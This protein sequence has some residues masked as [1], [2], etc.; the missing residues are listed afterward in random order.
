MGICVPIA[1]AGEGMK[2]AKHLRNIFLLTIFMIDVAPSAWAQD[3][4]VRVNVATPGTIVGIV[5][6]SAK[7]PIA[8]ATVT[9]VRSGA[10]FCS[11]TSGPVPSKRQSRFVRIA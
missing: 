7:L 10:R 3:S 8:G 6:N 5:T 1:K 11:D 4:V 2:L 9:A